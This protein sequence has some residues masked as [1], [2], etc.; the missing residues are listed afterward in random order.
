MRLLL[1]VFVLSLIFGCSQRQAVDQGLRRELF[2]ECLKNVP[3]SPEVMGKSDWS[4][5]VEF[6]F[7]GLTYLE[8][9]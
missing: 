6:Y 3:K 2:C 5:I 8:N 4:K 1:L 9:K 7:E